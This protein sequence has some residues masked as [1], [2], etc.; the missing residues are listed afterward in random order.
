MGEYIAFEDIWLS[1]GNLNFDYQVTDGRF[2]PVYPDDA[3]V[4]IMSVFGAF[5]N[6]IATKLVLL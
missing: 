2:I 3:N 6:L 4:P 5:I 1:M